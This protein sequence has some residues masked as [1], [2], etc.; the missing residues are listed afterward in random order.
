MGT[1]TAATGGI[2]GGTTEFSPQADAGTET[3]GEGI[4]ESSAYL[5][6]VPGGVL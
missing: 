3:G 5:D 2:G 6:H 1:P 4:N